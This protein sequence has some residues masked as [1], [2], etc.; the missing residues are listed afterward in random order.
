MGRGC[1]QDPGYA[2]PTPS[3]PD[4]CP[5]VTHN[6]ENVFDLQWLEL[7]DVAPEELE[8]LSRNMV[9][10][11][12]RLIDERDEC[13]ELIVDLTQER[14]YLQAQH[15]PSPLKSSSAESTPSPTSSLSSEDKQ[16]L[17][18]ELADTK[19]R[20]RRVRQELEE[21]TEQLVDTRHEVDQLV[22][23]LQKVK[24]ENIQLAADARSAR[25]Y[26]D[27]LDSLR[28]K[29]NRVERLEMELVRCREKLHDVDFYK[30]R[31]EVGAQPRGGLARPVL[32]RTCQFSVLVVWG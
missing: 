23:E 15:P 11:L 30:A 24:Q 10:H 29:A 1:S 2:L 18:V 6:Q 28:E 3:A 4:L 32:R 9:F 17:A 16:H 26:R 12:R 19:A 20:L 25:A 13:T 27:E 7:P 31:M 5:Q 14:D 8:A 21:K 22:L